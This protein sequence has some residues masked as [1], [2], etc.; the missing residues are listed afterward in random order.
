VQITA[1][2]RLGEILDQDLLGNRVGYVF[3]AELDH[4]LMGQ[5]PAIFS[6]SVD[7]KHRIVVTTS[8]DLI[9][10]VVAGLPDRRSKIMPVLALIDEE[11][12]FVFDTSLLNAHQWEMKLPLQLMNR[13][14][15]DRLMAEGGEP[16][17]WAPGLIG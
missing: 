4:R 1:T 6:D 16:F 12:G 5:F 9:E 3:Y 8:R 14:E 7:V 13:E 17:M 11:G 15:Y 10:E 2:S